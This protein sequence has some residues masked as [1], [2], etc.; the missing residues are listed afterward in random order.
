M[1]GI[2]WY[3]RRWQEKKAHSQTTRNF[4]T[5]RCQ[6]EY[7]IVNA[8][9]SR[10]FVF[11]RVFLLSP[12]PHTYEKKNICTH[13]AILWEKGEDEPQ[14]TNDKN[15]WIFHYCTHSRIQNTGK[16]FTIHTVY[17]YRFVTLSISMVRY[18]LSSQSYTPTEMRELVERMGEKTLSNRFTTKI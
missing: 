18:Y 8:R 12:F 16:A 11:V 13:T 10:I 9:I 7:Y 14:P 15:F 4:A 5:K 1:R 3:R 6:I 17:I 2:E